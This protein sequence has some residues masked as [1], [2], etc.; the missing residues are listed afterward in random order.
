M[1]RRTTHKIDHQVKAAM[2]WVNEDGEDRDVAYYLYPQCPV[3]VKKNL[4]I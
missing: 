4:F 3:P 2:T 1:P